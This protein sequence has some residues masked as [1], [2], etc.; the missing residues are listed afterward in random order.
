[1][2]T[3][4]SSQTVFFQI[5]LSLPLIIIIIGLLFFPSKCNGETQYIGIRCCGRN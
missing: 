5:N 2:K 4:S 3:K 1:M